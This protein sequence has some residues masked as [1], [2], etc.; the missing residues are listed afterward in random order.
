ME[1]IG[2]LDDLLA[3]RHHGRWPAGVVGVLL[4]HRRH[5]LQRGGGLLEGGGLLAG[6]FGQ[7]LARRGHLRRCGRD[8]LGSLGKSGDRPVNGPRHGARDGHSRHDHGQPDEQHHGKNGQHRILQGP[9]HGF[10]VLA[11]EE[12]PRDLAGVILHGPVGR[13]VFLSQDRVDVLERLPPGE[14]RVEDLGIVHPGS[15]GPLAF[16][17]ERRGHAGVALEDGALRAKGLLDAL[18]KGVV[19]RGQIGSRGHGAHDLVTQLHGGSCAH[20][21]FHHRSFLNPRGGIAVEGLPDVGL[22]ED[23]VARLVG[24]APAHHPAFPVGDGDEAD[25]AVPHDVLA[26]L[27]DD[28]GIASRNRLGQVFARRGHLRYGRELAGLVIDMGLHETGRPRDFPSALIV[29]DLVQEIPGARRK[30]KTDEGNRHDDDADD[31][32]GKGCSSHGSHRLL[33]D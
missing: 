25:A 14:D 32:L 33:L 3:S 13:V 20:R 29:V 2:L 11:D 23:A 31:F 27:L 21:E 16:L 5:L 6:T 12:H 19:C 22:G 24:V 18:D 9:S 7:R 28:G 10:A 15:H 8:L 30:R 17:Q 1:P 26:Q 4:G